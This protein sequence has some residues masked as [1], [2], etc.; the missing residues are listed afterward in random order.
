[1]FTDAQRYRDNALECDRLALQCVDPQNRLAYMK[2]AREWRSLA[3]DADRGFGQ[4]LRSEARSF[5]PR[6]DPARRDDPPGP[7]KKSQN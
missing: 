6:D 1:M 3:R 5:A 4:P 7:D 2:L